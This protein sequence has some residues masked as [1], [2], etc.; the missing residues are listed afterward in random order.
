MIKKI[1]SLLTIL[2]VAGLAG[3]AHKSKDERFDEMTASDL[4]N[5]GVTLAKKKKFYDAAE[6]FEALEARY[7]FGEYAEKAKLAEIYAYYMN[8]DW[9]SALASA[10]RFIKVHP[11]HNH[12]DYAFYMKGLSH[13][14]ESLGMISK[15]LP[16]D[17]AERNVQATKEAFE[18]FSELVYRYPGSEYA[19]DAKKRMVYLRNVIAANELHA[20]RF[21]M[22]R[23]AYLAAANRAN[24]IITHFDQSPAIEEA[25][26]IQAMAYKRMNLDKLANDSTAVLKLNFPE[27]TFLKELT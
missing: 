24:Y 2:C 25:L 10:E 14:S 20:A 6:H 1:T 5:T 15:Y 22:D 27:S 3:C 13:F 16:M 23:K 26:Y 9:P 8:N 4:Y 12:V 7:P 19:P 11:R 17:R 21:N 18:S